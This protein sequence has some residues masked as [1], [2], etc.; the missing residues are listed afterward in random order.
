MSIIR[1]RDAALTPSAQQFLRMLLAG[2]NAI[3]KLVLI[4]HPALQEKFENIP[5]LLAGAVMGRASPPGLTSKR[6]PLQ[7]ERRDDVRA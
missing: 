4:G 2:P 6:R 7:V 3:A 1:V 5:P